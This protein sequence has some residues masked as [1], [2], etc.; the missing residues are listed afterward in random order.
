MRDLGRKEGILTVIAQHAPT[1]NLELIRAELTSPTDWAIAIQDIHYVQHIASPL[2]RRMPK[3]ENDLIVPAREGVINI[4]KASMEN[5][6][7]R[8]VMT[9]S[10]MAIGYG[11]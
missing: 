2:P 9:S 11:H 6:V 4:L 3:D 7:K 1:E 8:V 5:G 10:V